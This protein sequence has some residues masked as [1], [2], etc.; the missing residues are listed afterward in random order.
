MEQVAGR[1]AQPASRPPEVLT[2]R[3][4]GVLRLPA[5]GLSNAEIAAQLA[6]L[7]RHG[8]QPCERYPDQTQRP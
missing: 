2:E 4:S 3:E 1:Q 8:A 6:L 7:R 5:R